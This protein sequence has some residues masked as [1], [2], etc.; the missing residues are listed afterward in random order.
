MYVSHVVYTCAVM[1]PA[2]RTKE[3]LSADTEAPF[4]VE[5]LLD[6][7]DFEQHQDTGAR[8][9]KD[10]CHNMCAPRVSPVVKNTD[11]KF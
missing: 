11:P 9:R 8:E 6:G 10:G 5:Q 2:R 1:P 3:M 7:K 4:I